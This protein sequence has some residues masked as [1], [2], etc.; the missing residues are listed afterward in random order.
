[1]KLKKEKTLV[2]HSSSILM[3]VQIIQWKQK[4][5]NT[6]KCQDIQ[7]KQNCGVTILKMD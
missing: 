1:M 4:N 2:S 7:K 5:S 6:E 3:Y